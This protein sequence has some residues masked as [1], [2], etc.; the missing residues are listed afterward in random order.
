MISDYLVQQTSD[1]LSCAGYNDIA[2]DLQPIMQDASKRM[3]YR[4]IVMS[5]YKLPTF[6]LMDSRDDQAAFRMFMNVHLFFSSTNHVPIVYAQNDYCALLEDLGANT[7]VKERLHT[8]QYKALIDYLIQIQ[9]LNVDTLDVQL[10][11]V[12]L[13]MRQLKVSLKYFEYKH[14]PLSPTQEKHYY[15]IWEY[16]L[17]RCEQS[18][19]FVHADFHAEN[20]FIRDDSIADFVMIDFQDAKRG[21]KEYDLASLIED[22]RVDVTDQQRSDYIQYYCYQTNQSY[23]DFMLRYETIASQNL[24]RILGVFCSHSNQRYRSMIKLAERN[25]MR[26]LSNLKDLF[27]LVEQCIEK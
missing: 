2:F 14:R 26:N 4:V 13:L 11:D 18:S 6:I 20:I 16:Y 3:Y 1:L 21:F 23:Q 7:R 25:L 12:D 5:K 17:K 15:A 10:Q 22:V 27:N 8:S 9:S 19:V 24:M